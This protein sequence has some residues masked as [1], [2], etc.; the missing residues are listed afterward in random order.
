MRTSTPST[1]TDHETHTVVRDYCSAL[2]ARLRGRQ[3]RGGPLAR[4]NGRDGDTTSTTQ[5]QYQRISAVLIGHGLPYLNEHKPSGDYPAALRRAVEQ[6]VRN[7]GRLLT[8]MESAV[9][10]PP[11]ETPSPADRYLDEV[12]RAPPQPGDIPEAFAGQEDIPLLSG[13]D[14][15]GRE[16]R[17]RAL[18]RAG[19]AFVIALE[20]HRLM[21]AGCDVFADHVEHVSG[22]YG[23][24]LGYDI[25]S[26]E[27]DGR[28]RLIAVKTTRFRK[29][30]P[31]YVA[32]N[33]VA[34]SARYRA[35]LWL[36]RVYNFDDTPFVYHLNGPL[37]ERFRLKPQ[38]Y[39][40]TIR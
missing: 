12:F 3:R 9:D 21:E 24:G 18:A 27:V 28:D 14:Y 20:Q 23:R 22:E 39:R 33:E 11:G 15:L 38:E 36:Y 5:R 16:Q 32:S 7:N 13:V 10:A 35:R 34:V 19:E 4:H 2:A 17:N 30:T 31:F 26:Y 37:Y 6:Y 40:A 25:H 29:E 1:T 8:L